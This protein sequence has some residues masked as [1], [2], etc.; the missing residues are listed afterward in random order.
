MDDGSCH[1][2]KFNMLTR[3]P[4]LLMMI[5]IMTIITMDV[6]FLTIMAMD[7]GSCHS[8]KFNMMT[9]GPLLF[10]M[11]TIMTFI[12]MD[13]GFLTMMAMDDGSTILV[14]ST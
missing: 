4:L 10:M 14:S 12:T 11:I 6:G 1:S 9:R 7:D 3:G 8:R 2:G 13:V 5:T